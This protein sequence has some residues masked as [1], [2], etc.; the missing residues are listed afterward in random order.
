MI[1]S[2]GEIERREAEQRSAVGGRASALSAE[3]A[4]SA[5]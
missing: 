5:R 3:S 1:E 4:V 2:Q